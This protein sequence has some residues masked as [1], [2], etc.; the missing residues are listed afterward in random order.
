[1]AKVPTAEV[2]WTA[3]TQSACV[4]PTLLSLP[5]PCMFFPSIWTFPFPSLQCFL[6]IST[7]N[8][9]TWTQYSSN[10]LILFFWITNFLV[11]HLQGYTWVVP[12]NGWS[13]DVLRILVFVIVSIVCC[14]LGFECVWFISSCLS[15]C[16][17]FWTATDWI[18]SE[19]HV[20][21]VGELLVNVL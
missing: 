4:I 13:I 16:F 11:E 1:M 21:W 6:K 10:I 20:S 7:S 19:L 18:Y 14:L 12:L 9:C 2:Y 8:F 17:L 15:S 5:L 3:F